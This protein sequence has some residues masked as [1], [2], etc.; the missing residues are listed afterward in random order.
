M[1]S[2]PAPKKSAPP[3]RMPMT[4][5]EG[6]RMSSGRVS[7]RDDEP[8]GSWQMPPPA[9]NARP[10][11]GGYSDVEYR[12]NNLSAPKKNLPAA[13]DASSYDA[14]YAAPYQAPVEQPRV[15]TTSS[16]QARNAELVPA[17]PLATIT[18]SS[19]GNTSGGAKEMGM[20]FSAAL[21]QLTNAMYK[22]ADALDSSRSGASSIP[23]W[24]R[25]LPMPPK[26]IPLA[27]EALGSLSLMNDA[28]LAYRAP[29]ANYAGLKTPAAED[30]PALSASVTSGPSQ[31]QPLTGMSGAPAQYDPEIT[32]LTK[33]F[34][35][36]GRSDASS[37][38]RNSLQA[39]WQRPNRD[40]EAPETARS[41]VR[42][43][44]TASDEPA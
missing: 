37:A 41:S 35:L 43:Q 26:P 25:G 4:P 8:A 19:F 36:T 14:S 18:A 21:E 1:K 7:Q 9:Y 40:Q 2:A 17:L 12:P 27:D 30:K 15:Q 23:S 33:Q 10:Q 28:D 22:S 5:S 32:Q 39:D 34:A 42:S 24:Q 3:Q 16:Q 6:S 31:S 38:S 29:F 20:A 44:A 11:S 13:S